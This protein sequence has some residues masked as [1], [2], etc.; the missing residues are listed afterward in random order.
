M[1]IDEDAA[2]LAPAFPYQ[3][4]SDDADIKALFDAYNTLAQKILTW[5]YEHCLPLYMRPSITGGLLDY[6][7]YCLYGI[8]RSQLGYSQ[9]GLV[10][11][12]IDTAAIN[13]LAIDDITAAISAKSI[14][15]SDDVFKRV[16]T[17][18][19]YKGDGSQFSI[20]WLKKRI[21]R[22]VTGDQGHAWRFNSTAPVS[23]TIQNGSILIK[24][25]PGTVS[26]DL[27]TT[28]NSLLQA[29]IVAVPPTFLYTAE[30]AS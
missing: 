23:I 15:L 4:F 24:I 12:S 14:H 10:N 28:L 27:V 13:T 30:I 2:I 11:G 16:I 29:G 25:S 5:I 19:F 7:A 17:W 9:I 6:V 3:Q 22:F 8:R 21:M 26:V 20:P 18:N 1:I